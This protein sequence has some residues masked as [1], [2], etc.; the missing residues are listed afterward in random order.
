[1][2]LIIMISFANFFYVINKNLEEEDPT[3]AYFDKHTK[4]DALDSFLMVYLAGTVGNFD[5][6]WFG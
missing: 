3:L 5:P 6:T 2:V 1:M 4:V